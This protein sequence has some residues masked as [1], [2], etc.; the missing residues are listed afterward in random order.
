[1]ELHPLVVAQPTHEAARRRG[2]AALMVPDEADDVAVRWV[3]L[4]ICRRWNDP[5]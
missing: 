5:C 1:V 2:E 3:G 4:L